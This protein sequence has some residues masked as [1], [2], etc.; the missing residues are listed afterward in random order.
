M[1]SPSTT[2][3][4]SVLIPPS[5]DLEHILQNQLCFRSLYQG[6]GPWQID[7]AERERVHNQDHSFESLDRV[8][9][10]QTP[11]PRPQTVPVAPNLEAESDPH[12]SGQLRRMIAQGGN[13]NTRNALT[14][15]RNKQW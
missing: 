2:R 7:N 13:A 12:L 3:T 11:V 8:G 15:R 6:K 4:N 5:G 10:P 14:R 1:P 9:P